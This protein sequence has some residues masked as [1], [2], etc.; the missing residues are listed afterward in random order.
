MADYEEIMRSCTDSIALWLDGSDLADE[1]PDAF[2]L[3]RYGHRQA[4]AVATDAP[5]NESAAQSL[6]HWFTDRL[7]VDPGVPG[8]GVLR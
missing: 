4:I 5:D 3:E 8:G 2:Q 6:Q 7:T 1:P